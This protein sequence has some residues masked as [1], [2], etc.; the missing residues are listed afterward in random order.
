M[1]N[2]FETILE[3]WINCLSHNDFRSNFGTKIGLDLYLALTKLNTELPLKLTLPQKSL[4]INLI[5]QLTINDTS[6]ET[7]LA[8]KI[9]ED[10][11][12]LQNKKDIEFVNNI[13]TPLLKAE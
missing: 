1:K 11:D 4:I 5:I 6:E 2:K 9:I 3:F 8:K 13:L 12:H 10:L 7:I